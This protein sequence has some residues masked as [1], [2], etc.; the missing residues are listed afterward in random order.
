MPRFLAIR[1]Q[2]EGRI[3]KTEHS[4]RDIPLVG[5]ALDAM[6]RRPGGFPRYSIE[7]R[8]CQPHR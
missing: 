8:T 5:L 2:A 6:K 7:D 1:I 4:Q 3:L